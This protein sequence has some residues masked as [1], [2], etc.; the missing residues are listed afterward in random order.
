[1]KMSDPMKSSITSAAIIANAG[2]HIKREH[3]GEVPASQTGKQFGLYDCK[4]RCW[5]G[6]SI[7]PALFDDCDHA[8]AVATVA[9]EQLDRDI[10]AR[11]YDGSG[12]K[13]KD[14]VPTLMSPLEALKRIEA[15][16]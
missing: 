12:L 1:M 4:D 5:L 15:R 16:A 14:E 6:N 3:W 13:L 11:L 10:R 9:K 2:S 8:R 7:G